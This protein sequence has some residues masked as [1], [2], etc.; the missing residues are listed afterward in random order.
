MDL[1]LDRIHIRGMLTILPSGESRFEDELPRYGMSPED[2]RRYKRTLG[3]DR[4]RVA[5]PGTCSSDLCVAGLEH[6]FKTGKVDPASIDAII[7]LS[8]TPDY[9]FP[10]TSNLIQGRV[11]LGREVICLDLNQGCAGFV[12]GLMQAGFM[13][14]N[15]AIRRVVLMAAEIS[16][17]Q[18]SSLNRAA[19]PL[20][21][22]GASIIIVDRATEPVSPPMTLCARFDGSKGKAIYIPAGMYRIPHDATT[23]VEETTPDGIV[24]SQEQVHMDGGAVLNFTLNEVPPLIE[25]ALQLAGK[26]VADIDYFLFHQPNKLILDNLARRFGVGADKMPNHLAGKYGNL[27]VASI[28]ALICDTFGERLTREKFLVCACGFGVGLTWAAAVFET[29][30]YEFCE[31]LEVNL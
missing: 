25:H 7:F 14:N 27:S 22:D 3:L 10:P 11:G 9:V 23:R 28:S 1:T 5:K 21:G 4:H 20:T 29:G 18:H 8:Q 16:T 30:P 13:L 24:R 12:I 26:S 31:M 6:L 17:A 15:P 2:G 19:W